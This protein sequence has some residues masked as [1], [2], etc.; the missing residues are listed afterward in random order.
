M[1]YVKLCVW[2][3]SLEQKLVK[4]F[5][6]SSSL[7]LRTRSIVWVMMLQNSL[8]LPRLTQTVLA[9]M[10]HPNDGVARKFAESVSRAAWTK[11]RIGNMS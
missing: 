3:I 4:P 6:N 11:L 8:H 7:T 1:I 5:Q 2:R 9:N 10:H